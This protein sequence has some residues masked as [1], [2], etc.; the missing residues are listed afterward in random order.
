MTIFVCI[1]NK[2]YNK[3]VKRESKRISRI[4]YGED[5]ELPAELR[6]MVEGQTSLSLRRQT[7]TTNYLQ[8]QS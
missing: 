3:N 1:Y 4:I 7:E 6:K 8:G 2:I 5:Q